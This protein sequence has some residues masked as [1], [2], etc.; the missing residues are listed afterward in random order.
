MLLCIEVPS[1]HSSN[2]R[3]RQN[4]KAELL[5]MLDL[6]GSHPSVVIWSL[7][8]E[9]WGAPA[10]ST[11]IETRDYV[12]KMYHYMHREHP[13]FLVVGNDGWQHISC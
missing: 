10:I 3:S 5:R 4:H 6:I 13:Q 2:T 1:P 12:M 9:D 11:N 7:Y 8:N